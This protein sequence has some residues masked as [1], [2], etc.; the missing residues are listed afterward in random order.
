MEELAFSTM[1]KFIS[2]YKLY[3]KIDDLS[4]VK[5]ISKSYRY[6]NWNKTPINDRPKLDLF[7]ERLY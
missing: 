5:S 2:K 7:E 1:S 6:Q 3:N 4:S